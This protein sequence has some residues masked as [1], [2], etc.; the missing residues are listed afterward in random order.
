MRK[1][2]KEK[3]KSVLRM[4]GKPEDIALAVA[5]GVFVAFFPILGTHTVL[6]L[7]LS[8]FFG[9]SPVITLAATFVNNPWTFALI[10]GSGLYAGMLLMGRSI[11]EVNIDWSNLNPGMLMELV[12]L[13]FVPFMV[14]SLLLGLAG[15]VAGYVFMLKAV[16]IYRKRAK[17]ESGEDG[18]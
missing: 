9:V 11:A 1:K 10:H 7:G 14:G 5:T 17:I 3:I 16:R 2:L 8:W 6:A 18:V 13:L 12:K 4:N 15:A